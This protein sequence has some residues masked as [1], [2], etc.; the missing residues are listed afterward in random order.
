MQWFNKPAKMGTETP[1][2]QDGF[3]FMLEP[4]HAVTMWL[5]L[6]VADAENGCMRYIP[7]SHLGGI[8]P[9]KK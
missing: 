5:A 4:N 1:P 7:R 2:H 3:Y 9:H 6:D 8:R